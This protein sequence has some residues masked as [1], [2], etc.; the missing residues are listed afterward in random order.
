MHIIFSFGDNRYHAVTKV[1]GT[2]LELACKGVQD[3]NSYIDFN[4]GGVATSTPPQVDCRR[5]LKELAKPPV[6]L[7]SRIR[8]LHRRTQRRPQHHSISVGLGIYS[9]ARI[10]RLFSIDKR[11]K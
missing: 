4:K 11:V 10:S 6:T 9:L 8:D 5:C 3:V 2:N 1:Q 7:E